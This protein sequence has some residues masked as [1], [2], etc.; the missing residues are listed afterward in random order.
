VEAAAGEELGMQFPS[1]DQM[2]FVEGTTSLVPVSNGPID[3]GDATT[4][5]ATTRLPPPR[6]PMGQAE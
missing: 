2:V 5:G 4:L 3:G 6:A 1:L